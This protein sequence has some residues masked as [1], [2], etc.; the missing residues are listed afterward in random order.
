MSSELR[1]YNR[2]HRWAQVWELGSGVWTTGSRYRKV[3]NKANCKFYH[4]CKSDADVKKEL[5]KTIKEELAKSEK[6]LIR[7]IQKTYKT[8]S[9]DVRRLQGHKRR[10]GYGSRMNRSYILNFEGKV[11][12]PEVDFSSLNYK[13][14][15]E[16]SSGKLRKKYNKDASTC[17]ACGATLPSPDSLR[18]VVKLNKWKN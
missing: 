12:C 7:S 2:T 8:L 10:H 14:K 9:G 6:K 18:M 5:R 16:L 17:L 4:H 3:I 15:K 1:E 13:Q 11:D